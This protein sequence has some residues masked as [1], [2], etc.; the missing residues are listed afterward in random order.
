MEY[1]AWSVDYANIWES[2]YYMMMAAKEKIYMSFYQLD[3]T[4][5]VKPGMTFLR[6][7][8]YV[9]G[10]QVKVY[11]LLSDQCI[12]VCPIPE[13]LPSNCEIHVV[14]KSGP[15]LQDESAL[16]KAVQPVASPL[17][18]VLPALLGKEVGF[19][20]EGEEKMAPFYHHQQ[21]VAV[22][23]QLAIIGSLELNNYVHEKPGHAT[24]GE[25]VHAI[26]CVVRPSPL[27][28]AYVEDNYQTHGHGKPSP[29]IPSSD[30]SGS[31]T[32]D[33]GFVGSFAGQANELETVY[34]LIR[35]AKQ[36]LYIE[37]RYL[38]SH[39]DTEN[40]IVECL[41]E[42]LIRAHKN[43]EP[44]TMI[45]LVNKQYFVPSLDSYLSA[46]LALTAVRLM[47]LVEAAGIDPGDLKPRFFL[48]SLSDI[49]ITTTCI[50][51][52]TQ[53]C[54]LSS[55]P[56]YDRS[57]CQQCTELGVLITNP[58]AIA[59]LRKQLWEEHLGCA[60]ESKMLEQCYK[61]TGKVERYKKPAENVTQLIRY[62]RKFLA[63]TLG[64]LAI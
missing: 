31:E 21:Y 52:D 29:L 28:L 25:S 16:W 44:F 41:A 32:K 47:A 57:L 4:Q 48:G 15:R 6:L 7:L 42:R 62:G 50:I 60:D 18:S 46:E 2:I 1:I 56:L 34:R 5:E 59:S 58:T 61:E 13:F 49:S 19:G 37:T 20:M 53:E 63:Y 10:R 11:V 36:S 17:L 9:C 35:E 40:Q 55:S 54:L 30:T 26:A 12:G 14:S 39:E 22:D 64:R 23:D 33:L 51:Q 24:H 45:I 38:I 27:F 8:K 3:W 43:K